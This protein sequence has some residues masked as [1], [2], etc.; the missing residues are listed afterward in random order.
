LD[1]GLQAEIYENDFDINLDEFT[2]AS[3]RM[4]TDSYLSS[5]LKP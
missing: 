1:M 5:L 2:N 3:R 4:V